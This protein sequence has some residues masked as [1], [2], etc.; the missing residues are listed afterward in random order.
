MMPGLQ[1]NPLAKPKLNLVTEEFKLL[2]Q[3]TPRTAYA[4]VLADQNQ[5]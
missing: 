3:R 1:N 5:T 2:A 4:Y